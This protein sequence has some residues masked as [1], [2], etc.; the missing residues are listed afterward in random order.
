M[1]G[2]HGKK[3]FGICTICISNAFV[4]QVNSNH[5]YIGL[6]H[7]YKLILSPFKIELTSKHRSAIAQAVSCRL[8][9]AATRVR[10][11]VTWD[12]W[13]TKW[14]WG[15]FSPSTS[16]SPANFHSTDCS[17]FIIIRGWYSWSVGGRRTKLT[18]SHV[19]QRKK[20]E[21]S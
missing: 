20:R 10:A 14:H 6:F 4:I 18:Q 9:T 17:T 7:S 3:K 19:T 12:L 11:Q 13:W 16:V 8:P 5:L 2:F 15:R 1:S 21:K